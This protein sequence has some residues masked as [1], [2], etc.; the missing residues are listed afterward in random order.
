MQQE[1]PFAPPEDQAE[2][3]VVE[4]VVPPKTPALWNPTAA[5]VWSVLLTPAFGAYL[6]MKNWE[7][8][9]L[10]EKAAKSK[11]WM[12]GAA[13]VALSLVFSTRLSQGPDAPGDGASWV[14]ELAGIAL[15]VSWYY[16]NGKA[17]PI[18]VQKRFGK[19]YPR[20][21]WWM[22]LFLFHV[23]AGGLVLVVIL[24]AAVFAGV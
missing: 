18:Y 20:R 16:S 21:D 24:L 15:L 6:Q 12:I 17:Q 3:E 11:Q 10:P 13:A 1:N 9:G 14:V 8:L 23:V 5:A 19:D 22:V 4:P 2:V 7:A